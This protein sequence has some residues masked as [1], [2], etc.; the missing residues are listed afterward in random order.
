VYDIPSHQLLRTISTHQGYSITHL[1]SMLKPPDLIGHISLSL[2]VNSVAD[3][4]EVIPV[5]PISP[6]QRTRD[7]KVREAHN[8]PILLLAQNTVSAHTMNYEPSLNVCIR[9]PQMYEDEASSY[10]A[11]ELHRDHAFFVQ[12]SSFSSTPGFHV[13]Q[14][15]KIT[16]L[17]AEIQRLQ[18]QLGKA[19]SVNDVMWDTIVQRAV[20]QSKITEDPG[21]GE[22]KRKRGRN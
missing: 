20:G 10:T 11:E 8:I 14:Q 19:K 2:A 3:A 12:P 17:E 5:K 6:F 22:R 4:K 9:C 13:S 21:E 7:A 1:A 16:D 15:S 18:E